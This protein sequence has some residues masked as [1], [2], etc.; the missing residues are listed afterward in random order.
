[1]AKKRKK[2]IFISWNSYHTRSDSISR[3]MN[4][5]NYHIGKKEKNIFLSGLS[6]ISKSFKT[7]NIIKKEKPDILII[8]NNAWVLPALSII[9][10]KLTGTNLI[11]DTHS[12]GIV[13]NQIKYPNI[14]KRYFAKLADLSLVTN[15]K[16]AK[17][18]RRWGGNAFVLPDPPLDLEENKTECYNVSDKIN[19]CYINTYSFDE[20][21]TKVVNA[22]K[23]LNDVILYITGNY[24]NNK[25]T[26]S[27]S[28][29]IVHTGFL[30]RT[31]YIDLLKKSDVIMVLTT[32]E[33]T[34]QCGG[35]EAL[36]LGKPLITSK[37]N[38]LTNYFKKG[39]VFVD[40]CNS[41]S[42]KDGIEK[43]ITNL[44]FYEKEIKELKKEK[45]LE[46]HN[47]INQIIDIINQK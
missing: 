22:V 43:M 35:N 36:S 27:K 3:I 18:V 8:T 2:T 16:H 32:R 39:T 47:K 21:Y 17:I 42:I 4:I 12:C 46:A 24:I 26:L 13:S 23:D 45:E 5:A 40:P 33:D 34:F 41:E 6:F 30:K 15:E 37:T 25:I 31:Q 28:E 10:C 7:I 1:M 14:F 29:N 20:P 19:I 11:F 44:S 38:F 9:L